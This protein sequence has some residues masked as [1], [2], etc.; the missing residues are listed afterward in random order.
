VLL[1]G[2]ELNIRQREN[3][4]RQ[5]SCEFSLGGLLLGVIGTVKEVMTM[6]KNRKEWV[7]C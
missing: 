4:F 7:R 3:V 1:E 2:L 6:T 5:R